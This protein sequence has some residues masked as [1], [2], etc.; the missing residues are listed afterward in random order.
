MGSVP[1]FS[2]SFSRKLFFSGTLSTRLFLFSAILGCGYFGLRLFWARAGAD[3]LRRVYCIAEIKSVFWEKKGVFG[4]Q[5]VFSG[6]HFSIL[7]SHNISEKF[8]PENAFQKCNAHN[9]IEK[10]LLENTFQKC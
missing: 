1:L 5:K 10:C 3:G 6:K 4:K 7:I 8:F 9:K 2:V